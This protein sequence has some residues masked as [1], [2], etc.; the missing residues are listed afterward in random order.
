M[1]EQTPNARIA[2]LESDLQKAKR[3][4]D[5]L[6]FDLQGQ[7]VQIDLLRATTQKTVN[8]LQQV[9]IRLRQHPGGG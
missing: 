3:E 2:R 4:I 1:P 8:Q 7:A 9:F 6:R 5:R